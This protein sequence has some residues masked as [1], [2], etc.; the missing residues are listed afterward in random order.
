MLY[1]H[2]GQEFLAF[3]ENAIPESDLRDLRDRT[4]SEQD[5][6]AHNPNPS[7]QDGQTLLLMTL[8]SALITFYA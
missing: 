8:S 2:V 5:I 1:M 6:Q 7:Y 4:T 3:W